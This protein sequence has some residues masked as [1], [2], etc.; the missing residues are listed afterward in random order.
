MYIISLWFFDVLPT[1]Y[2]LFLDRFSWPLPLL[3]LWLNVA[4]SLMFWAQ[5][6]GNFFLVVLTG[7]GTQTRP[8]PPSDQSLL[9]ATMPFA[10]SLFDQQHLLEH[11]SHLEDRENSEDD[12]GDEWITDQQSE[13]EVMQ[14]NFLDDDVDVESSP[15]DPSLDAAD[16]SRVMV[17][18][19]ICLSST[20]SL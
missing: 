9:S 5:V 13:H 14:L 11:V 4:F 3:F 18:M 15:L 6:I 20:L 8:S 7:P 2:A 19:I 1:M 17:L 10:A 16:D 12:D